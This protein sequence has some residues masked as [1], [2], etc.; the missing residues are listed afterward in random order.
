MDRWLPG[1]CCTTREGGARGGGMSKEEGWGETQKYYKH[2]RRAT[3]DSTSDSAH[4]EQNV[5]IVCV[6]VYVLTS[7]FSLRVAVWRGNAASKQTQK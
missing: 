6:C 7:P 3:R 5:T 4:S 2:I 1:F